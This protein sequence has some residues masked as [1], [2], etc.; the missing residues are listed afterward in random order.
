MWLENLVCPG[1]PDLRI[2]DLGGLEHKMHAG[3]ELQEIVNRG[4]RGR[5]VI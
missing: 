1:C 2:L 4:E 5:V 3:C